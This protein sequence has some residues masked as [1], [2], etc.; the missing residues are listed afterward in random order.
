[1][2][3]SILTAPSPPAAAL[4]DRRAAKQSQHVQNS[5]ASQPMGALR[6]VPPAYSS[7]RIDSL[8]IASSNSSPGKEAGYRLGS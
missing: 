7:S 5:D 6:M 2:R 4:A 1:M 8:S 3:L